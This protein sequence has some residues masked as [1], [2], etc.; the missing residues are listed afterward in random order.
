[1]VNQLELRSRDALAVTQKGF[2]LASA[3]GDSA[4]AV[5]W[6]PAAT[7]DTAAFQAA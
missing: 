7:A 3:W 2:Q 1:M 4:L 6:L 5:K